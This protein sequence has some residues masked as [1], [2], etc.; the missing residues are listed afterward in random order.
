MKHE[1]FP[2]I[3]HREATGSLEMRSL[4]IRANTLNRESRTVEAIISTGADVARSGYVERLDTAGA[5]LSRLTGAPV[6]DSHRQG[7][8]GDVLGVVEAVRQDGGNLIATIK[9]SRRPEAEAVIGDIEDGVLRGVSIGYSVERW[10]ETRGTNGERVRVAEAWTPVEVS[11]VAVPAD[12]GAMIRTQP[13]NHDRNAHATEIRSIASVSGLGE[14][15]AT[16]QIGQ[17]AT[18]EQARAAAFTAMTSRSNHQINPTRASVGFDNTD[19][20]VIATRAGEAL[21]ARIDPTHQLSEPARQYAGMS[22]VDLGRDILRRAY[23]QTTGLSPAAIITRALHTTSDFSLILGDTVGRT[24]RQAY[25]AAPAG[26]RML[27]RQTT[28]RD[29]R[30]KHRLQLGE[31]PTLELV[32][33][34]GEFTS[35]SMAEAQET[36]KLD[37][38]GRMFGISRQAM[39]NDDL[40][41]FSDLS[42]PFG[43]AAAEFEAK[44]L[45]DLL[46]SNSRGGPTMSDGTALFHD[47]HGN[48]TVSANSGNE[49][50]LT[51]TRLAMRKQTGLSGDLISVTPRYVLVPSTMETDAQRL[52]SAVQAQRTE[53]VNPFSNLVLVVDPRLPDTGWYMAADTAQIDGLEYCYLEGSPGPQI[54]S[55]NGF[56]I[57]GVQTKVRLD[58]GAG[59]VDHRGWHF[60]QDATT[61]I[62]VS[63]P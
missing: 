59:F 21:F 56:E 25:Q 48:V 3:Y 46:V 58:F 60:V 12:P 40:G 57:D 30:A 44:F 14:A 63:Q 19:P 23:V 32:G 45:V 54:E 15:W 31:F 16:Q 4:D 34:H 1:T 8:T 5:N 49:K 53:D 18:P 36:Y 35:G 2:V 27:G 41:A 13:G 9:F 6:L 17:G 42:R 28:A 24:M 22:M 33:E 43:V 55:R 61:I 51:D 11:L 62:E 10:G 47:D 38:F 7:S 50:Q 29:F 20:Q 37:T 52:L 39:I 26:V